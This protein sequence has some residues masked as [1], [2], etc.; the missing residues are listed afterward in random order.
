MPIF[1]LDSIH[2]LQTCDRD[3]QVVFQEVIKTMDCEVIEGFRNQGKQE[4]AFRQ[5][6]S[7]L[8]W[9]HSKHN[10]RPSQAADVAPYP[11]EWNN[12]SRF[13]WFAG[14]VMG[15]ADNL[16]KQGKITHKIRYG[17]DWNHDYDITDDKGL[18]DLVHFELIANEKV[19]K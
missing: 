6:N 1:S 3:L 16:Y 15:T 14:Y 18:S 4:K 8:D 13:F 11:I 19:K 7:K 12:K 5:G 9:P 10:T 17:G 2:Q